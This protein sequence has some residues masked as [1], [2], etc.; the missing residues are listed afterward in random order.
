MGAR[1][2]LVAK[3]GATFDKWFKGALRAGM[4]L[5]NDQFPGGVA[6]WLPSLVYL[7]G[8]CKIEKRDK[9]AQ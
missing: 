1:I 4:V 7:I 3:D 2:N 6:A 5:G 8:E 9:V